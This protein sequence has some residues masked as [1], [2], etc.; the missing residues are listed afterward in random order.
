MCRA[1]VQQQEGDKMTISLPRR[2]A[3]PSALALCQIGAQAQ[4]Q[5]STVQLYGV[6]DVGASYTSNLRGSSVKQVATRHESSFWGVRGREDLG[7]GMTASFQYE[8]SVAVDT[9]NDGVRS[10]LVGLASERWGAVTLGRQYDLL[11]DHVQTDPARQHSITAVVPGN[12][13]RSLGNFLDNS[14]KYKSPAFGPVVIGAMVAASEGAAANAGRM[15]GLNVMYQNPGT[16]VVAT[17]LKLEGASLRPFNDLGI[18]NLFG[19]S[20]NRDRARSVLSEQTIMALGAFHDIGGWR[21][22]GNLSDTRLR[23]VVSGRKEQYRAL[24]LG[25]YTPVKQGFKLGLGGSV[26]TLADSRWVNLHAIATYVFS[27]RSEIYLRAV[28]QHSSGPQQQ[29]A[30][31]YLEGPS[32]S[33]RQSVIGAGISHRF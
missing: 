7:G 17:V 21:L 29:V 16:R 23:A 24:R 31:L 1:R 20:M 22:L 13:D 4:T 12:Y 19:L 5:A 30:A 9:G 33:S 14:I 2:L 15:S 25:A 6:L 3:L 27:P 10:A 18:N 32:S 28:T 26:V 11:V 8:R